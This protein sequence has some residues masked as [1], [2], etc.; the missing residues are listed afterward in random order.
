[1]SVIVLFCDGEHRTLWASGEDYWFGLYKLTATANGETAWYDEN[2]SNY[3]NW[4]NNEPNENIMCILYTSGGFKDKL[5]SEEYYYT[6]KKLAGNFYA[7][8][9]FDIVISP[10][11]TLYIAIE[12]PFVNR[13]QTKMLT[14]KPSVQFAAS[15]HPV[16]IIT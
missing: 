13:H 9:Y 12:R 7:I 15:A 11:F 16:T 1:M 2:P 6:C 8:T 14:W 4:A 5:C 10:Y 3:I